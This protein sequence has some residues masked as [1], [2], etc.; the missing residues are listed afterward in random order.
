MEKFNSFI[1]S[2]GHI[3]FPLHFIRWMKHIFNGNLHR[4]A[5][6]YSVCCLFC[7]F[8]NVSAHLPSWKRCQIIFTFSSLFGNRFDRFISTVLRTLNILNEENFNLLTTDSITSIA[9]QI[10]EKF[11][12]NFI[13]LNMSE[14]IF[15]II[16]RFQIASKWN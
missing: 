4:F 10:D 12:E 3:S 9:V 13:M 6:L 11:S 2:F 8:A 14:L 1:F 5:Q 16:N 7:P 15:S